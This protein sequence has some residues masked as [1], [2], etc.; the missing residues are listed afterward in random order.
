[1]MK[2]LNS[3]KIKCFLMIAAFLFTGCTTQ[4]SLE[5]AKQAT[6][7]MSGQSLTPPP[8]KINDILEMLNQQG[9]FDKGIT[10][11]F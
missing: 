2:K 3:Y 11:D 7:S 10:A 6:I 4:M 9:E 5:K 8:R 1:M